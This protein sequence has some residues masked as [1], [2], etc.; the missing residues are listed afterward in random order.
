MLVLKMCQMMLLF[1]A[2]LSILEGKLVEPDTL[3]VFQSLHFNRQDGHHQLRGLLPHS[4]SRYAQA[5]PFC[6]SVVGGVSQRMQST[7]ER[8]GEARGRVTARV[9]S[10][11]PTPAFF[12]SKEASN[13]ACVSQSLG[14]CHRVSARLIG[15]SA[16]HLA[17][18]CISSQIC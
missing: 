8:I 17:L 4:V 10:P 7:F 11:S 6:C 2:L 12:T 3:L 15:A 5:G 16:G 1:G 14:G 18:I 9:S 13:C